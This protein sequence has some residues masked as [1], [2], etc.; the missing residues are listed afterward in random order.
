MNKEQLR[1]F[2]DPQET[3]AAFGRYFMNKLEESEVFHC[4]LSGGSTP[5]LLFDYLADQ[6]KDSKA[7]TKLHVYWGDERCVP[8]EDNESNF[9]M[10]QGLL[11]SRVAIP[12]DQIHRVRGEDD[13]KSE[14][15]RYG[16]D[17]LSSMNVK[18][19]VPV[20]DLIILGMGDDGHTASIFP[21]EIALLTSDD[22]CAVATHPTSG[23]N[24]ITLTGQVINAA[25]E[26]IFLVTG[27]GKKQRI[28][29]IFNKEGD[30]EKYPV[31][32]VSPASGKLLWYVDQA[33]VSAI[34]PTTE[35]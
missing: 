24:R 25:R 2:S 17:L 14:A 29:E 11:L 5:K 16:N 20:F 6:Y 28:S 33:A 10:T 9:K 32:Y 12:E 1:V 30:W 18:A 35:S 4:A 34:S 26:V 3:A 7:W 23:Q 13:P 31:S 21:H 22:T 19:G 27:S 15:E 8:P